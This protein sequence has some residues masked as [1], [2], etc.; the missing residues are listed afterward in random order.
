MPLL[1]VLLVKLQYTV[2]NISTREKITRPIP[3]VGRLEAASYTALRLVV[4]ECT[5]IEVVPE[6]YYTLFYSKINASSF[7]ERKSSP[8]APPPPSLHKPFLLII[9]IHHS[10]TLEIFYQKKLTVPSTRERKAPCPP[11]LCNKD[12]KWLGWNGLERVPY[13]IFP[14]SELCLLLPYRHKNRYNMGNIIVGR[15]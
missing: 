10:A 5:G 12:K 2:S 1:M 8:P 13:P 6:S 4:H 11:K 7:G 14:P 15:T 3:L 9:T